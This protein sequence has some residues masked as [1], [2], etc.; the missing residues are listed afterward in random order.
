MDDI[1]KVFSHIFEIEHKSASGKIKRFD[2]DYYMQQSWM[3]L[4]EGKNIK[5]H[6]IIMLKHELLEAEIMNNNPNIT[7]EEAH[8]MAEKV[9]NYKK[10]LFEYLKNNDE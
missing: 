10:E 6:D 7:Y 1:E 9:Y 5:K 8:A 3:R 2:P 4:R